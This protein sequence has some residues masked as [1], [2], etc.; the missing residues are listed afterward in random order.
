MSKSHYRMIYEEFKD[1]CPGLVRAVDRWVVEGLNSIRIYFKDG[2]KAVYN[3]VNQ[4]LRPV[5][6]NDGSEA[7]WKRDFRDALVEKMFDYQYN[8]HTLA[9]A[10]GVSQVTISKWLN[11][12]AV[13][14]AYAICK[15]AKL[16]NCTPNDLIWFKNH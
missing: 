13:P 2:T 8:Q 6:S 1:E 14:N 10:I 4:G 3:C 12:A 15:L 16:F 9:K 7:D 5:L 11:K